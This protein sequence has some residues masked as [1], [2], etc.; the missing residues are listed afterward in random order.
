MTPFRRHE[1]VM[2]SCAACKEKAIITLN[3]NVVGG[4]ERHSLSFTLGSSVTVTV[5]YST[6]KIFFIQ[7]RTC[8]YRFFGEVQGM[9]HKI[10]E[11]RLT[12]LSVRHLKKHDNWMISY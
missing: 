12:G 8:I 10:F 11:R 5:R 7:F 9:L 2:C 3:Q 6:V 4:T 1:R